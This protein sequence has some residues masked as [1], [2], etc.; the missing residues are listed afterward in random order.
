[1]DFRSS[2]LY[3]VSVGV[4]AKIICAVQIKNMLSLERTKQEIHFQWFYMR[5]VKIGNWYIRKF[6]LLLS[7]GTECCFSPVLTDMN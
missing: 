2:L 6:S 7:D 1:M 4:F 5:L 3:P